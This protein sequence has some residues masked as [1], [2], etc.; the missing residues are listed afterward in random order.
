MNLPKVE[1]LRIDNECKFQQQ[2]PQLQYGIYIKLHTF[3][4]YSLLQ[5]T[6]CFILITPHNA[7]SNKFGRQLLEKGKYTRGYKFAWHVL[8]EG[9]LFI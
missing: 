4:T 9:S 3:I 7:F 2:Q 1:N 5:K 8:T 6:Q